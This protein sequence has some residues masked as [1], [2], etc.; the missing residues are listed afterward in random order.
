MSLR[1]SLKS[2]ALL[3][4]LIMVFSVVGCTP[5][6]V[7]DVNE[8]N[9]TDVV[10]EPNG[11]EEED[12]VEEPSEIVVTDHLGREI[13]FDKPAETIVS[14]YYISSSILLA[15]GLKDRVIGL[16]AKPEKRPIYA[17]AAPEFLELPSVG[18][19][20]EFDLEGTAALNPD[21]VILSVR[22]KDS[23]E[24]LEKLGIKVIA[25]NPESMEELEEAIDMIG[26]ATGN[27]DRAE[28]LKAYY[29]EKTS[30]LEKLT[31]GK[32]KK[33]VYLGGNS[34]FLTTASKKMY[35]DTLITNA[36]GNNVAGEIDDTYWATISYEQLIQ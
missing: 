23:A 19:M 16:E 27:E 33:N 25:I 7:E 1:K 26:K 17:L 6:P 14:G 3:L 36:G 21:L 8:D 24:S 9:N 22:L 35:Q 5:K 34:D 20:K 11:E 2:I 12:V 18:T 4:V 15:L 28:S 32:E 29:N 30:E 13:I 31:Q 10:E